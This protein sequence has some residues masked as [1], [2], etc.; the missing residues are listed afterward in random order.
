MFYCAE[1]FLCG[2][3]REQIRVSLLNNSE[4]TQSTYIKN[5]KISLSLET[6]MVRG[7]VKVYRTEK[8]AKCYFF[9]ICPYVWVPSKQILQ[10]TK[11]FNHWLKIIKLF[12]QFKIAILSQTYWTFMKLNLNKQILFECRNNLQTSIMN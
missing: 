8:S 5:I 4:K 9:F 1:L 7:S 2:S 3:T 11:I 12:F 10:Y 6:R